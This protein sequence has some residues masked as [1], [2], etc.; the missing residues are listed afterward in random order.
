MPIRI[1]L[2]AVSNSDLARELQR[3]RIIKVQQEAAAV[4]VA[5]ERARVAREAKRQTRKA[6]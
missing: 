1:D 2:S 3:R 5:E 4:A 6:S